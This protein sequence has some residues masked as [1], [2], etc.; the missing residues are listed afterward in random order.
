MPNES[1]EDNRA[2]CKAYYERL[3]SDPE[4]M[5]LRREKKAEAQRARRSKQGF[6]TCDLTVA[7]PVNSE[8]QTV[9]PCEA[10]VKPP[11]VTPPEKRLIPQKEFDELFEE[12]AAIMEYEGNMTKAT[13]EAKAMDELAKLFGLS[14]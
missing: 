14:E 5:R 7:K 10:P 2:Y 13:A 8:A 1:P 11:V 12:R 3:K 4:R 6:K 9:P